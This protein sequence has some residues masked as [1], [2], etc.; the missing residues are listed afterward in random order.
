MKT[1]TRETV[2]SSATLDVNE[3]KILQ[4]LGAG[5]FG[6]V[7]E[8]IYKNQ[9]VALKRLHT[10]ARNKKAAMQSFRAET[11]KD[12]LTLKHPNIVQ[13]LAVSSAENVED[14]PCLLMEYIST[15]NLQH[16]LDDPTEKFNFSRR[17]KMAFQIA[18]ALEYTHQHL[19]AHLDLKPANILITSDGDCKLADFGC[20]Q[21]IE[22]KR[23]TTTRC[24]LTGT[25]AYRAPE[26]LKGAAPTDKADV[27][28]FGICLWQLWTRETPYKLQNHETVI[29]QVVARNLRPEIPEGNEFDNRYRELMTSSWAA[30]PADRPSFPSILSTL[31][32]W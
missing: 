14:E 28:S 26:L 16:L 19:I 31:K 4:L 27:Y 2:E 1:F 23:N 17:T 9:R 3:V 13:V 15:K 7:F 24:Y 8:A 11:C 12:I 29:F 21:F 6:S 32:T 18:S 25:F 5:G 30:S 20:S 22:E 10:T